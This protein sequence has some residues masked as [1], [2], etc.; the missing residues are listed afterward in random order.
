MC[1][2]ICYV[3]FL[4]FFVSVV[5]LSRAV[6]VEDKSGDYN[7]RYAEYAS[8]NVLQCQFKYQ[9]L[10]K[11][12]TYD[13]IFSKVTVDGVTV[14]AT[15]NIVASGSKSILYSF[16][17]I[18]EP[19]VNNQTIVFTFLE[20]NSLALVNYDISALCEAPPPVS[21]FSSSELYYDS[22]TA[23]LQA[24]VF[25]TIKD[26][27]RRYAPPLTATV[28][29]TL[30][31]PLIVTPV[32]QSTYMVPLSF[33]ANGVAK[34]NESVLITLYHTRNSVSVSAFRTNPIHTKIGN[35]GSIISK[36]YPTA[37]PATNEAPYKSLYCLYQVEF[38]LN[39]NTFSI[40]SSNAGD[41]SKPVLVLGNLTHS[42]FLIK[43]Y[44]SSSYSLLL[45][46]KVDDSF[47]QTP[48][49]KY[50]IPFIS[51]S[52]IFFEGG[53]LIF[54]YNT[55]NNL[56]SKI[57]YSYDDGTTGRVFTFP[58]PYGFCSGNSSNYTKCYDSYLSNYGGGSVTISA[59]AYELSA[60]SNG[61]ILITNT[62]D[63]TPPDI[64]S[65]SSIQIPNSPYYLI[66]MRIVDTESGFYSFDVIGNVSNLVSG[67][68][69][70]GI[71]EFYVNPSQ[72]YTFREQMMCDYARNCRP[73][74]L[75]NYMTTNLDTIP[76]HVLKLDEIKSISFEFNDIDVSNS[77]FKNTMYIETNSKDSAKSYYP[78]IGCTDQFFSLTTNIYRG[79]WN[80]V[81][82]RYEIPFNIPKNYITGHFVFLL[83]TYVSGYIPSSS[84][85][86]LFG[87][88]AQLRVKSRN[89]DALGPMVKDI[90]MNPSGPAIVSTNS[91][92]LLWRLKIV[93]QPNGFKKGLVSI[94]STADLFVFNYTLT[95]KSPDSNGYVDITYS[96]DS[97]CKSQGYY[98]SYVYLEDSNGYVSIYDENLL[99]GSMT[100]LGVN[101]MIDY[102]NVTSLSMISTV[103]TNGIVDNAAPSLI[104]FSFDETPV[105]VFS[106]GSNTV[107][108]PRNLVVN[109]ETTDS[110]GILLKALPM[111]YI[112]YPNFKVEAFTSELISSTLTNAK[113]RC[114]V[115]IPVG[116]GYP[117]GIR[118]SI[119]GI[120]DNQSN[121]RGYS[122][123]DLK[124]TGFSYKLNVTSSLDSNSF[125]SILSTSTLYS[126]DTEFV[127]QGKQFLSG[128]LIEFKY[129]NG[130]IDIFPPSLITNSIL[131]VP[132][133]KTITSKV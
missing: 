85:G 132:I 131:Y 116:F 64:K 104:S 10:V 20:Q 16:D 71:Y 106:S 118:F 29:S 133:S 105:D 94:K 112:Q 82:Q 119:F 122:I 41:V 80:P 129:D 47:S 127:I 92:S 93:D 36:T 9:M 68:I 8:Q 86:S 53:I 5:P 15:P 24:Y 27:R 31:T 42:T 88:N 32:N 91:L 125:I 61:G 45:D 34:W 66:R 100:Y 17:V 83:K 107:R 48:V 51:V 18:L 39:Q 78:E 72:L 14:A 35:Q 4:V 109:F 98:I 117:Y 26:F 37:D 13:Y 87:T 30:Y 49:D 121:F 120:I 130:T 62:Y 97:R 110:N 52:K 3:L 79:K 2:A 102:Y 108:N 25:F 69:N 96:L 76:F 73:Y 7:D 124:N 21:N 84:L 99:Y 19:K 89:G 115:L 81:I 63:T 113:Y 77:D 1:R 58:Y 111:V 38:P 43:S 59:N 128:D 67:N 11:D 12:N 126:R 23:L 6:V 55:N 103:C 75:D 90:I 114:N 44:R 74:L 33:T 123:T 46:Q 95:S 50:Y 70:D 56:E 57:V 28:D 54:R 40:F 60:I 22:S 65:V 101:P